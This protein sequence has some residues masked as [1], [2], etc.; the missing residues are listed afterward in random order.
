MTTKKE[1]EK[2]KPPR[3]TVAGTIRDLIKGGKTNDEIWSAVKKMFHLNDTKKH[4]PG[5]YRSEAKR[6]KKVVH[7]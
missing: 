7:A 6:L 1:K 5:W 3:V 2:P 4:Y